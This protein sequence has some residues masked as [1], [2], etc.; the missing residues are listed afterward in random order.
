[1]RAAVYE[2]ERTIRLED[3]PDPRIEEPTDAVVRIEQAAVCGSDLWTYRGMGAG[4]GTRIGHEFVGTVEE[5]GPKV[6]SVRPGDWVIVPFRYSCGQCRFCRRGLQSSCVR[7]GFWGRECADA[8]QGQKARVPFADGTLVR[9]LP[10]GSRPEESLVPSLLMLSDVFP[11]GYHAA[12]RAGI[13]PG[14]TVVVVGDGAVGVNAVLASRL[15]GAG[16]VI[17][18]GSSHGDRNAL[19][20][21]FGADEIVTERGEDAVRAV[22]E[23]T[24]GRMADAVLECVGT[25]ASFATALR[26]AAPGATVSY[27]GLPHGVDVPMAPLFSRNV[28]ITGG[29]CPARAYIPR[30][31]PLVL[32]GIAKPGDALTGRY[33]FGDLPRAYEDM[34]ARRTLKALVDVDPRA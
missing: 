22:E 9:A 27:V 15:L 7:G 30:L 17:N 18:A 12:L 34:D 6:T 14:D 33:S 28:T 13:K 19:A 23:L 26:L 5:T 2:G 1:M 24:C 20:R 16:R 8:G 31:L 11:T 10:D 32:D 4:P 3:V 25:P 21:R 29:I